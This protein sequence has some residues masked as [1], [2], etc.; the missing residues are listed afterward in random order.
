MHVLQ[1][2]EMRRI[3]QRAIQEYLIPGVILMENAG[4]RLVEAIDKAN[5]GPRLT[6]IA[7]R[8]NN[9]GD[10]FVVARHFYG[11]KEVHVWTA[12]RDEDYRG[13]ALINLQ[14][15]RK[16][17]VPITCL[18][19]PGALD[20]LEAELQRTDLIVDAL[21]G[22]GLSRPLAEKD[23]KIVQAINESPAPVLAVDIPSGIC[24]NS[25]QVLGAAVKADMTIT[26]ALPKLGHFLYPGAAYRGR[27][28]VVDI[29]IP[30]ALLSGFKVSL[31]TPA[32]A[33]ALL[34]PRPAQG[35]KGTFGK[36][37]LVAGSRGMSGAAILAAQAALRGGCGLLY[38]AVP[39]GIW[40]IVA[41]AVAEAVLLPLPESAAGCIDPDALSNLQEKWADC[42]ALAVWPGLGREPGLQRLL[43]TI[44]QA[45]P[46][47]MVLDADA[48]N[49]LAVTGMPA[50][51]KA[52]TVL[53]PHPGEAA[54]L[55][56]TKAAEIQADR[57]KSA[58]E[59]AARY[60]SVV[61]LKGA[62]TLI[63]DPEGNVAINTT[64]NSG[65]AT[66]GSGDVLTGLI[67]SFLAQGLTGWQAAQLAVYLHGLAGDLAAEK[68]GQTSLVA[69]DLLKF[70][71]QAYLVLGENT[72]VKEALSREGSA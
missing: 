26:F 31:L 1:A 28:E 69:G 9:G 67:L 59:L 52:P 21:F 5:Y 8:G 65:M 32:L 16:L 42:Q 18:Q 60:E 58:R 68:L 25:G 37:L 7:G 36:A 56:G 44:L 34:P 27:L 48:L 55:L 51:R 53:T 23:Q 19:E 70:I 14:I 17:G 61:V 10:G 22:T 72:Y 3:D 63:A 4:L 24:A 30:A 40:P 47:P 35:H 12:V 41:S 29:G 57:I 46:I 2:E 38:A 6:I 49:L 15:L 62:Y 20:S 43:L 39:Q 45:C 64:G 50:E 54:R 11:K 13:D 33:Q 66:A 71:S